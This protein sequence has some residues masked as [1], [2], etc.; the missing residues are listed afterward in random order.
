MSCGDSED[1]F[2]AL[3]GVRF[4]ENVV[5]EED[6]KD[7]FMELEMA[8]INTNMKSIEELENSEIDAE[9][10]QLAKLIVSG[11]YLSVI[12]T[13][14][15]HQGFEL[16][17]SDH[18]ANQWSEY[19]DK[20]VLKS[21]A[22]DL[23][24]IFLVAIAY[25]NVY[26][27]INYTGPA[28]EPSVLK[29]TRTC[30]GDLTE[31]NKKALTFLQTN[32]DFPHTKCQEPYFLLMTRTLFHW[33]GNP[34]LSNWSV[35]N[36]TKTNTNRLMNR[37]H[38][39]S[40]WCARAAVIHERLLLHDE[41]SPTLWIETQECYRRLFAQ[42]K[43]VDTRLHLEWGLAQHYFEKNQKGKKS[44][45]NAQ[46]C[47]K[48]QI[49]LT[50]LM[51]KRTKYQKHNVA[52]MVVLAAS[53]DT[54]TV[55]SEYAKAAAEHTH[56]DF[57]GEVEQAI[58]QGEASYRKIDLD[59][60]NPDNILLE[61][62]AFAD[63]QVA[64]DQNIQ[65]IDQCILLAMCL[66]VANSNPKDGLTQEQM[67]PFVSRVLKNP[68]NWMVYSTGLLE[69]AWLE[70]ERSHSIDRGVLQVQALVDQHTTRLTITQ[71]AQAIQDAAPAHERLQYL[72]CL[73]F[74][75][76]Y[77]LRRDLAERYY[78]LGVIHSALEVFQELEMWDEV[79][80]CYQILEKP[81]KAQEIVRQRL[82]IAPTPFMWCCLGDLTKDIECYSTAWEL[83]GKRYARAKRSL[84]RYYFEHGQ[85]EEAIVHLEQ[86]TSV[87]PQNTSTWF[88][89]G[90]AS[91]RAEKWKISIN[92]FHRVVQNDPENGEAWGNIGSIHYRC[93]HSEMAFN[94]FQEG[95]KIKRHMWQMWEN[96]AT[97]ALES[98][99]YG[100]V[101]YA[102][103]QLLD[104]RD[105]HKRPVDHEILALL[106]E[107]IM[108]ESLDEQVESEDQIPTSSPR[109][110]SDSHYKKQL[111]M[112][113]GRIASI[114]STNDKVWQIYAAF[115]DGMN[116]PDKA[117]NCRL[118]QCRALQKAGW[119]SEEKDVAAV[120]RCCAHLADAYMKEGSEKSLYAGRLF[121][122][123]ILKKVQVN[124]SHLDLCH[125][126]QDKLTAIET[127]I[128]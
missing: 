64:A 34:N 126:L 107:A 84:G 56:P 25:M 68:N 70:C 67:L 24:K 79:V 96:F 124:F 44:F 113:L 118:K 110:V 4:D 93:G 15:I 86:S 105:K 42:N 69:K 49:Q 111:A 32:G 99:K 33:L 101:M 54:P 98:K 20:K 59:Q 30:L 22:T 57:K 72:H 21:D 37:F 17:G 26:M 6:S 43:V 89:L 61:E 80:E 81:K 92:A 78:K 46:E 127:V 2:E 65:V 18:F 82:D 27:Q 66:D 123:G 115:N 40:W 83:S 7:V 121:L 62:I 103:H 52:Q 19:L 76:R 48:L 29:D 58:E 10:L 14:Q 60:A 36:L 102:M 63:P 74:P 12:E 90:V 75:P 45:K 31:A 35:P 16:V 100:D 50:G 77:A 9:I 88:L 28:L 73:V 51:G 41:P 120:C 47:S 3:C 38:T 8:L 109:V 117:L 5:I 95:L 106:V 13:V 108:A 114:E 85:M 104:L 87:Q 116:R 125:E 119:D 53:K 71:D 122:R 1:E 11:N 94:A 39:S 112:L 23:W 97:C 55:G 91:M 128:N